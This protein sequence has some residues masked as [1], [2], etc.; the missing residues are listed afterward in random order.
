MSDGRITTENASEYQRRSVEARNRNTAERRAFRDIFN[1]IL[2]EDGG[3]YKGEVVSKKT[4]IAI[5]ALKYLLEEN[6]L[7][8]R[9]FARM[10][11]VVRDTAGEKPV[12]RIQVTEISQQDID[13]VEEMVLGA[14]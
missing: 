13:E 7:D 3:T 2:C 8:A 6:E 10:F 5:K 9:E 1:E 12:E 4:L 11:E 14:D